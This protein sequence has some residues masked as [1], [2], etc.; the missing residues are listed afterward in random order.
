ME[1]Q[2]KKNTVF[3]SAGHPSALVSPWDKLGQGNPSITG[4]E[5]AYKNIFL[6]YLTRETIRD[7]LYLKTNKK[8]KKKNH[9]EKQ[10]GKSGYVAHCTTCTT[11]ALWLRFYCLL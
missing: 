8:E 10:E 6:I 2:H 5:R 11:K 4:W 9:Q 7:R 3:G 1:P